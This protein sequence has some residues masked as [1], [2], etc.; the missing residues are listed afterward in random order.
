MD[1]GGHRWTLV[2]RELITIID[3]SGDILVTDLC[4][5]LLKRWGLLTWAYALNINN[6]N[7]Y[8]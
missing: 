4:Q 3:V 6:Y 8:G 5:V 7:E 2:D 1:T